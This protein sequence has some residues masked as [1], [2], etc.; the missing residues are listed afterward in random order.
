MTKTVLQFIVLFIILVLAQVI[1]SKIILFNVAMPIIFIYLILRLPINMS[2]NWTLTIAFLLGL[3]IDIFGNTQGMNALACTLMGAMRHPVFNAYMSREDDMSNPIPSIESLGIG[4]YM[5]YMSTMVL[6]Y[7][8]MI[9]FIQAFTL[10][11][12]LLTIARI[13]ASSLLTIILL[14]GLDSLASTRREKR[15]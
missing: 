3:I 12:I 2:T 4:V 7:C 9:F 15:L 1:C 13:A 10:H 14:F 8:I 6:I 5:K 11:N